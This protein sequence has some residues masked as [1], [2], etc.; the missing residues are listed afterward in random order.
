M[1]REHR[2]TDSADFDRVRRSGRRLEHP[3]AVMWALQRGRGPTR[4]GLAASRRLGRAVVRNRARRRMREALRLKMAEIEPGWDVVLSVQ[5]RCVE[6][7]W[8]DIQAAVDQLLRR[9]GLYAEPE[10]LQ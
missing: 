4:V 3:L 7:T 1:Q 10:G 6:A 5:P 8:A 9:A 2:L